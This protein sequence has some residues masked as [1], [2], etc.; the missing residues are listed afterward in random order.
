[1]IRA[2]SRFAK[3]VCT[4]SGH[5]RSGFS[6]GIALLAAWAALPAMA[7]EYPLAPDQNVVG[8]MR[9]Y[10]VKEGEVF[11]DI[12]RHFDIGYTALVTANPGV[13]PWLPGVG[14]EI[15][16]PALYMMPDAPHQGVVINL[17]QWRLFYFPPGGGLGETFPP[18][19]GVI[20]RKAPLGLT[21]VVSKEASPAWYP[22]PSIRAERPELPAVVPAGAGNPPGGPA[23]PPGW[24]RQ[25][26]PGPDTP[27]R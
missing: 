4:V 23:L 16:I 26:I 12:A 3:R 17:A 27:A 22:P 9:R 18:G 24:C 8:E 7:A 10:T 20:G 2:F 11:A 1:M 21:R 14:R 19:L 15:T 13:D 5:W 25:P 6:A